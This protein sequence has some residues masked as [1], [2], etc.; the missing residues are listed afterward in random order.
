MH[1]QSSAICLI[2]NRLKEKKNDNEIYRLTQEKFSDLP[3]WY[4]NS[5]IRKAKQYLM[6]KPMVFGGKKNFKKLCKNHLTDKA[7]ERLK[8]QWKEQR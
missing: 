4:I 7:K 1:L 2:Y 6:D 8:K 3:S 5:A